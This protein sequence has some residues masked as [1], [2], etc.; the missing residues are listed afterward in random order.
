MC[1]DVFQFF[2]I[3]GAVALQW[4]YENRNVSCEK[5]A[6]SNADDRA[7]WQYFA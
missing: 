4:F 2:G 6:V 3:D 1:A 5:K 7:C